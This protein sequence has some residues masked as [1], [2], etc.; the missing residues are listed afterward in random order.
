MCYTS[1][2]FRNFGDMDDK[3]L[4]LVLPLGSFARILGR[5]QGVIFCESRCVLG[6][7]AEKI[8]EKWDIQHYW[9][10]RRE[11]STTHFLETLYT[12][13]FDTLAPAT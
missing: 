7:E 4:N 11:T 9:V 2:F 5:R 12:T 3:R 6:L 8:V 1:L 13:T 10:A